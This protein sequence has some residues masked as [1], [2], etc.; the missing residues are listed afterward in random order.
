M[1][2]KYYKYINLHLVLRVIDHAVPYKLCPYYF[3]VQTTSRNLF[4]NLDY[5]LTKSLWNRPVASCAEKQLWPI[6]LTCINFYP[7]MDM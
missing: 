7:S 1:L 6:L 5:E 3:G 4:H 2:Q